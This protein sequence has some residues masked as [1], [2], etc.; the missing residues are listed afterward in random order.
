MSVPILKSLEKGEAEKRNKYKNI[1]M[2]IRYL[3]AL[4]VS[5]SG[6][7]AC[8]I[9]IPLDRFIADCPLVIQGRIV[10]IETAPKQEY[11]QD[12]AYIEV[13]DILKNETTTIISRGKQI[14]L[15]MPAINNE[16]QIS[17]DIRYPK[18]TSGLWI[19]REDEGAYKADYPKAYYE[20]ERKAE[21]TEA[22][23]KSMAVKFKM[24]NT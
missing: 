17:T 10:K 15:L 12:I 19:L 11:A 5:C 8:W 14:K 13:I 4:I 24:K 23:E 6:S 22:L 18:G 2:K 20:T 1:L 9:D 7:L 21:I 3:I 16:I